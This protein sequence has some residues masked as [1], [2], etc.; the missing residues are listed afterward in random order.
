MTLNDEQISEW[1]HGGLPDEQAARIAAQV[2]N[3]P[4]ATRRADRLRHLDDLLRQAVPLENTLPDELMARLG[5]YAPTRISNIVDLAEIRAAKSEAQTIPP[6]RAARF[7]YG[8]WQ[9][10]AQFLIVLGVGFGATQWVGAPP[11]TAPKAEYR[12][13]GDAP[14]AGAT[15]N[16]LVMVSG[17]TDAT[18]TADLAA[19]VGARVIGTRTEAGAW[20]FAIHPTR[21]DAVLGQ[22]R[23][24]PE[25]SMAEP[26]ED[27]GK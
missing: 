12:A 20:R 21:R 24:L 8:N 2:A 19:K 26:I 16:A 6:R 18:E 14:S 9:I 3:D 7:G 22:L 25:V 4:D 10:A 1:L 11:P 27:A 5:L 23:S 13:L 17:E 15:A